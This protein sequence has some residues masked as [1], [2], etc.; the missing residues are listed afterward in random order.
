MGWDLDEKKRLCEELT[1]AHAQLLLS[2]YGFLLLGF[3]LL[4]L[5]VG[6]RVQIVHR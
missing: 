5:C 2:K 6:I 3:L 1:H 4:T